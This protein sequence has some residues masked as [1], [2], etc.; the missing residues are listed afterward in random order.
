MDQIFKEIQLERERQDKQWGGSDHDDNHSNRDWEDW[1]IDFA[2]AERGPVAD[3][4]GRMLRIAALAV[5]AMQ[6]YDRTDGWYER[7]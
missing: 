7:K 3:F 5:A 2:N 1:I 6:S 4:R